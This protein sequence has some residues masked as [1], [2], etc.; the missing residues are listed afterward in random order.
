M[1]DLKFSKV[2]D[3]PLSAVP[4]FRDRYGREL[5]WWQGSQPPGQYTVFG[6]VVKPAVRELLAA[7]TEPAVLRRIFN[8]FE[9]MASSSDIQVP[10]LLQIEIF[11]WLVGDAP[12]LAAAWKFIG[13]D[14]KAI[15]RT[16]AR[17]LRCEMNL[18]AE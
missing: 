18:P 15:A 6:F 14:T 16:T 2:S 17:T 12:R 1:S 13:K 5:G 7:N 3:E 4:E 11:E 9:E 8:F 10:N